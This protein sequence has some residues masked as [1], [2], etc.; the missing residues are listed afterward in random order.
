MQKANVP[1]WNGEWGSVYQNPRTDLNADAINK[2]C[3]AHL[4]KQLNIYREF[5]NKSR[6]IWLYK[7]IGYQGIVYVDP[8]SPYM[9]LVGGFVQKKQSLGLDYWGVADKNIPNAAC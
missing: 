6:S 8:E 7:D 2:K 3:F 9:K 5:G 4:K 1:I